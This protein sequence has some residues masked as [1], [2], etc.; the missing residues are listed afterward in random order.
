MNTHT[1]EIVDAALRHP[2]VTVDVWGPGWAGYNRSVPLSENVRR[3]AWRIADLEASK[4]AH[5]R[6]KEEWW[7]VTMGTYKKKLRGE[8][9]AKKEL[10][11]ARERGVS[12][13]G[14]WERPGWVLV[15]NMEQ[16]QEEAAAAEQK[17]EEEEEEGQNATAAGR[18]RQEEQPREEEEHVD[19]ATEVCHPTVQFDV[20]WTISYVSIIAFMPSS[21]PSG[22]VELN[23]RDIYKQDDPH[24][25]ALGC[26]AL[27]IQ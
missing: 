5:E 3:R 25:D 22:S 24:V 8:R 20:V 9:G 13:P 21:H 16:E 14:E 2:H 18:K 4:S 6:K 26:G 27:L 12:D 11:M 10:E 19:K 7:N 1:Y 17:E 23:S 15:P